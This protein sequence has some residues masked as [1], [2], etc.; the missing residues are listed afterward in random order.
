MGKNYTYMTCRGCQWEDV[1]EFN[2]PCEDC[3]RH[4]EIDDEIDYAVILFEN[5]YEYNQTI[6]EYSDTNDWM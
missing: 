3:A 2:C 5:M 1:C 6:E 4:D